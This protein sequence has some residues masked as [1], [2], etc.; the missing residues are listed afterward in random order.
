SSDGTW[1]AIQRMVADSVGGNIRVCAYRQTGRGKQDAVRLGIEK[2]TN[3]LVM[4]LDADLTVPPQMLARFYA[5]YRDGFADFIN[6]QRLMYPMEKDAMRFLNLLGNI[7]FAKLVSWLTEVSI[8]DSL[9]GTKL[10]RRADYALIEAWRRNV[11][12]A[13]PFGDFELLFFASTLRLGIVD[14]PIRYKARSYG[15]TNIR[16][17]TDGLLLMR[18]C[19]RAFGRFKLGAAPVAARVARKTETQSGRG[20]V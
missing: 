9:C 2:A 12:I 10:L 4:I 16:R 15:A 17:F 19:L 8:G 11:G 14:V 20:A 13:D 18:Y 5:A 3:D 1:P 6:G 7:F